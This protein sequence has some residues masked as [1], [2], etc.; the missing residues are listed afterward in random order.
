MII[1]EFDLAGA[2]WVVVAY[3]SQDP[4]MLSVVSS[5]KSPHIVTGALISGAPES[6][7]LEEHKA[8]GSH[9][10]AT[11][12]MMLR[13]KLTIPSGIFLPRVMSIRQAGKKSNHG[14]NYNMKYRRFAL[15]NE[16]MEEDAKPIVEA[17]TQKAYPGLK[18]RYWPSIKKELKDNG[19]TLVNCFGRKVKLRGEWGEELFNQAYSFKPQSTVVDVVNRAMRLAYANEAPEFEN[20]FLGAQVH[21]SLQVQV[22]VPCSTEEWNSL[23]RMILKLKEYMRPELEYNGTKFRLGC[24]AKL[25]VN[26]GDMEPFKVDDE[27]VTHVQIAY[28]AAMQRYSESP[29]GSEEAVEEAVEDLLEE[30]TVPDLPQELSYPDQDYMTARGSET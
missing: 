20:F 24:D 19:R 26:W 14:L 18:D 5:G 12:I 22:R 1:L 17:Y 6:F 21:D 4:N 7:V 15:E 29:A 2:E 28:D 23:G 16:M 27:V 11:T 13:H 3:L 9:T 25:G 10:D 30:Q 8:V